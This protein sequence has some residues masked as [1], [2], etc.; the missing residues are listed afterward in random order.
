MKRSKLLLAVMVA[1]VLIIEGC[2][3]SG[4]YR[5]AGPRV[6]IGLG[7]YH[8]GYGGWGGGYYRGYDDATID[9]VHTSDTID[10]IEAGGGMGMP[11]MDMDM[12]PAMDFDF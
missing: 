10:A 9:A 4:R 3:N 6:G 2:A 12:G 1:S 11:D 8:H 7:F 5:G